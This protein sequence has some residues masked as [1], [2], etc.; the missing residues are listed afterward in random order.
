MASP[1]FL[2]VGAPLLNP[3]GASGGSW[4]SSLTLTTANLPAGVAIG[5]RLVL[6][7]HCVWSRGA[8]ETSAAVNLWGY[9]VL[10]L[11]DVLRPRCS[12]N[13]GHT[14]GTIQFRG[15]DAI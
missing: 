1:A 5:D 10:V 4:P 15:A 6:A 7:I 2:G 14:N 9:E 8:G 13:G 12:T 11:N 3:P